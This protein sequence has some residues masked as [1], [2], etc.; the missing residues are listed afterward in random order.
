M[1]K[2]SLSIPS[3]LETPRLKL[4]KY[5]QGDG[6]ALFQLLETGNNREYLKEHI[7][8]ASD[9]RTEEEAEI[10]VQ[11]LAKDWIERK[12]FVMGIWLRSSETYIGQIWI[13]SNNWKVPS[14]ELGWYIEQSLQNQG[15]A[16]EAAKA[17][18]K[19]I[20]ENLRA[21]KIIV[22]TR[23]D[24]QQSSKLAERLGFHK[25]GHLREHSVKKN[26]SR[27]GLLYYGLLKNEQNT[28]DESYKK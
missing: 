18:I 24:N 13:E 23:D 2:I 28:L 10:R 15:F 1:D 6:K 17:S 8:E 22:M 21:H 20:F 25:E 7:D 14:F 9:V 26:G 5:K 12:R 3:K 4:R 19:F 16:T 27:V 11:E